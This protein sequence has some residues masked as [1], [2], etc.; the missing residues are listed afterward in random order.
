M[1][2]GVGDVQ[3]PDRIDR[4]PERVVEAGVGG[5]AAIT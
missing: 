1:V 4:H 2:D 5:R 3:V